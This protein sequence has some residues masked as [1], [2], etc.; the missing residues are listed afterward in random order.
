M[1]HDIMVIVQIIMKGI[2]LVS[3]RRLLR[4]ETKLL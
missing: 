1:K 2:S 3:T 4:V